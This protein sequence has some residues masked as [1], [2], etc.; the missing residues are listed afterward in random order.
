MWI[1]IRWESVNDVDTLESAKESV[2]SEVWGQ[3]RLRSR[4]SQWLRCRAWR[5][6]RCGGVE[7]GVGT[8]KVVDVERC[9]DNVETVEIV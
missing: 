6:W 7:H 1:K 4:W 2:V 5:V 3:W 9:V 8:V